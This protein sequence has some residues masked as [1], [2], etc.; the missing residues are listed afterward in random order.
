MCV[1]VIYAKSCRL[2]SFALHAKTMCVLV[3][4]RHAFVSSC[5][6]HSYKCT[7]EPCDWFAAVATGL[8]V[9]EPC[10]WFAA[11]VVGF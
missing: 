5:H 3:N 8:L 10:E 11:A 9:A 4:L 6:L 2:V 1:L 7:A